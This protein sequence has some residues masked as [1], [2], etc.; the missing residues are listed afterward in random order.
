[1]QST[2]WYVTVTTGLWSVPSA[3]PETVACDESA[4]R[5]PSMVGLVAL[6]A[7]P[8]ESSFWNDGAI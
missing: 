6:Q 3:V 5:Y 8:S 2:F 7:E 1:V 4:S